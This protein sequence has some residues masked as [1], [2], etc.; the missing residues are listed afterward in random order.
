MDFRFSEEEEAI[1]G[2]AREIFE[3]ENSPER[4]KAVESQGSGIDADLWKQLAEANLLGL[5]IAEGNGGM[6]MGFFE[7]CLLLSEMGRVVAPVPLLPALVGAALPIAEFGSDA[8]KERWLAPLARGEGLLSAAPGD[9]PALA[10]KANGAGILLSGA[11]ANLPLAAGTRAVATLARDGEREWLALVDPA[12]PGAVVVSSKTSLQ[13]PV[14]AIAFDAVEVSGDSLVGPGNVGDW[15][16]PR[17]RVALA[18]VQLGVSERALEIT[19][20]YLKEREQFGA[21]LAVLPAVQ[22]R[23][24]DAYITLDAMRWMTWMA[25]SR[26]AAGKDARREALAAKYWAAEGGRSIASA[27]QHLHAGAGVDMDYPIHRYFLWSKA[28]ELEGGS[29]TQ[30]LIELGRDLARTGAE[31]FE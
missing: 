13:Q 5:A 2:L 31:E 26:I 12:A 25:A 27:T 10:A 14:A 24:A 15:L 3:K 11:V 7:V 20:A 21:P 4:R 16:A 23:C 28:L 1:R 22:H 18:A 30:Q 6:G 9:A 19:V 8:A 17:L 29:G